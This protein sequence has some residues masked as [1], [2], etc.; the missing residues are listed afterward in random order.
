MIVERQSIESA[1]DT[2]IRVCDLSKEVI[3]REMTDFKDYI[4]P[5]WDDPVKPGKE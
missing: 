5:R 1:R 3:V 2:A 4:R